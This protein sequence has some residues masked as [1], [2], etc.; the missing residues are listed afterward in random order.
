MANFFASD[1]DVKL[2][3]YQLDHLGNVS[4]A[5]KIPGLKRRNITIHGDDLVYLFYDGNFSKKLL[6]DD[7]LKMRE[8][9][10]DLWTN[11]AKTGNP[12][13]SGSDFIWKEATTESFEHLSLT[14][15]PVMKPDDFQV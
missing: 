5:D 15:S 14:T 11:F 2:Y 13:P 10:L 8:I 9:F 12:T 1:P 7:D 3:T 6:K 4:V